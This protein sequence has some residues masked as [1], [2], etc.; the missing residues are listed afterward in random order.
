MKFLSNINNIN[1]IV[2][3]YWFAAKQ[4]NRAQS[5]HQTYC[6]FIYM[7]GVYL[8]Y[9]CVHNQINENPETANKSRLPQ[10][11]VIVCSCAY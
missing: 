8:V 4:R 2:T 6:T 10:A 3:G 7:W 11:L 1:I 9:M 5:H